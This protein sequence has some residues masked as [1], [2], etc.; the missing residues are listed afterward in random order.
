MSLDVPPQPD[1][2]RRCD[3]GHGRDPI[4]GNARVVVMLIEIPTH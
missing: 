3:H 1:P 4:V 2:A